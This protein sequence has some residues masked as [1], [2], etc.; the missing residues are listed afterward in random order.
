MPFLRPHIV[1]SLLAGALAIAGLNLAFPAE[2]V[3]PIANMPFAA[4]LA[5]LP[6][7]AGATRGL[8]VL[9]VCTIEW[10]LARQVVRGVAHRGVAAAHVFG[11]GLTASRARVSFALN[12]VI[13]V[14]LLPSTIR[15]LRWAAGAS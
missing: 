12:A 14:V 13:A 3:R 5:N 9:T 15:V 10:A 2:I 6:G 11:D 7:T 4:P 8:P 1:M